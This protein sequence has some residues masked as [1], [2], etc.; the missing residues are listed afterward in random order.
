MDQEIQSNVRTTI[1]ITT[2]NVIARTILLLATNVTAIMNIFQGGMVSRKAMGVFKRERTNYNMMRDH[3]MEMTPNLKMIVL[4]TEMETRRTAI[5]LGEMAKS[6]KMT[7]TTL[8][9]RSLPGTLSFLQS[10]SSQKSTKKMVAIG[11][12]E[13]SFSR[14]GV[15]GALREVAGSAK[16][17]GTKRRSS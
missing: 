12:R 5:I 14:P 15:S 7:I 16:S 4:T 6:C 17:K 13:V 8:K 2:T 10:E 3:R 9:A 11:L 1:L